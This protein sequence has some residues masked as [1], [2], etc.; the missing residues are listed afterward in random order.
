[1]NQMVVTR[2]YRFLTNLISDSIT[3]R[4]LVLLNHTFFFKGKEKVK[5]SNKCQTLIKNRLGTLFIFFFIL[6]STGVL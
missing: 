2:E 5:G 1:M 6:V 4:G 3:A